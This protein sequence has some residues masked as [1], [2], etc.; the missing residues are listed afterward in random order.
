MSTSLE[1]LPAPFQSTRQFRA[2]FVKGLGRMLRL[3]EM[4]SFILVLANA[5]FDPGIHR[6]LKTQIRE[7]FDL[8]KKEFLAAQDANEEL[9][10]APDDLSVFSQLVEL[11][12]RELPLTEFHGIGPW[13]VQYNQLRSFR[14]SRISNQVLDGIHQPFDPETFHFNKPFLRPEFLWEGNLLGRPCRFLYNKFPFAELHSL[15]VIDPESETP[16]YLNQADFLFLW[17]LLIQ[18]GRGMPGVG[19][20]YN[21]FGAYAS[22]NHQHFQMYVRDDDCVGLGP[23]YP[24]ENDRWVHNGGDTDYP[25]ETQ[26]YHDMSS[27]WAA[28]SGLHA[29]KVAYN[30][31]LRP[32][33][34]YLSPRA[35]QGSYEHAEWT[36]GFAWSEIAGVFTAYT[37][38]DFRSLHQAMIREEFKQLRLT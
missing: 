12:L 34:V 7:E 18:L 24:I 20:G 26:K 15:L 29:E 9:Q 19:I 10:V 23:T 36:P 35:K 14:P 37:R 22:V 25:I 8:L 5:S 3:R 33:C 28:L 17:D 6:L 16:Q 13:E 27:A 1:L 30:L 2:A 4:G 38:S 21:A 32:G 31:L 11:G